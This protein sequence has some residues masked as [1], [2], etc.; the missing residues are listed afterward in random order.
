M[1]FHIQL[2]VEIQL[3]VVVLVDMFLY[4]VRNMCMLRNIIPICYSILSMVKLV[5]QALNTSKKNLGRKIDTCFNERRIKVI[6]IK[7]TTQ[8]HCMPIGA[9]HAIMTQTFLHADATFPHPTTDEFLGIQ[10]P[11]PPS[12]LTHRSV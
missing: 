10:P 7:V 6:S 5:M 9:L 8:Q 4:I 2:V 3:K 12:T 1:T 11:L